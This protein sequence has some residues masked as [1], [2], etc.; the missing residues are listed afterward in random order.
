MG[1]FEAEG[2]AQGGNTAINNGV[3]P[4]QSIASGLTT[5]SAG[6]AGKFTPII[7]AMGSPTSQ[8]GISRPTFEAAAPSQSAGL[9]SVGGVLAAS[10][11]AVIML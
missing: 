2:S 9:W 6:L 3:T 5:K 7:P 11:V 4:S 1:G 8:A 10:L